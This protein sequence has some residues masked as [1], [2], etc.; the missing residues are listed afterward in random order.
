LSIFNE[1]KIEFEIRKIIFPQK[2]EKFLLDFDIVMSID[3]KKIY[4]NYYSDRFETLQAFPIYHVMNPKTTKDVIHQKMFF[5]IYPYQNTERE[6]A[7]KPQ[8]DSLMI[9]YSSNERNGNTLLKSEGFTVFTIDEF[10]ERAKF[11]PPFECLDENGDIKKSFENNFVQFE[12]KR[13]YL[14]KTNS[15]NE[16]TIEFSITLMNNSLS[17]RYRELVYLN[18]YKQNEKLHSLKD[19]FE[20]IAPTDFNYHS[21]CNKH[22]IKIKMEDN[23]LNNIDPEK[24]KKA[25]IPEA[26]YLT[27]YCEKGAT[28]WYL[29]RDKF[30]IHQ[31][32]N[33]WVKRYTTKL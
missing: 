33:P 14:M 17:V 4:G 12:A 18:K 10:L 9:L 3:S 11:Q 20:K 32:L 23:S 15:H 16:N 6:I 25:F 19:N 7:K 29:I 30:Y 1:R 5:R 8:N 27:F 28:F 26:F 2:Y 24:L 21:D 31:V 13:N 22:F